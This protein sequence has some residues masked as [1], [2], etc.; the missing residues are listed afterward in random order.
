MSRTSLAIA[1]AALTAASPFTAPV[2]APVAE[3]AAERGAVTPAALAKACDGKDAWDAPAPPARIFG[4]TWYVGTCGISAILVT[5]DK[6]HVLV[7]AG[8][9]N[10][11]PLVL[12]N[13]RRAGFN[14]RDVHWIVA[15][16]EHFD[17]VG[18]L[19][20]LQQATGAKVAALPA[21]K[22]ALSSGKS[23]AEDPQFAGLDPIA[24][25]R[26]DRVLKDGDTVTL[27]KLVLTAHATPVHAPGSTSWTWTSCA[28]GAGCRKIAYAD[29]SSTISSDGYRFTD[30][31]Q[32]VAAIR[33][34][35]PVM[36]AL[37]CDILLTPHPGQSDLMERLAGQKP[38]ADSNACHAYAK[39]AEGR[40]SQRLAKESA[41]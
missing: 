27:G 14:P 40:L 28:P 11:A 17:H 7:D 34:G 4:N 39:A 21:Q 18:A 6:G 32:R 19:A 1:L 22:A 24:P 2:A 30:H 33:K 20:A 25:V 10:A 3:R 13:I 5:G 9:T 31:P 8:T 36:S 26:V 12:A 16:H 29:S 38:L 15:S 35:L 37:P 41:K 23:S